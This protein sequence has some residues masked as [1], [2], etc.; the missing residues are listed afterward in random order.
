MK[1]L[2]IAN[3]IPFPPDNGVRIPTYHAMRLMSQAGHKVA[4]AVLTAESF[5]VEERFK[6]VTTSF[7]N[8]RGILQRIASRLSPELQ[9]IAVLNRSYS[10]W[11]DIVVLSLGR[12]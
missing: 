4:L 6:K 8:G 3:E 5:E 11:R 10:L 9:V 7:C 12:G 1:I 2:F